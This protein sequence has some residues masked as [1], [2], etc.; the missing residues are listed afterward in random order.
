VGIIEPGHLVLILLIALI[1]FGPGRLG[2]LGGTLGRGLRDFRDATEGKEPV[3]PALSAGHCTACG[4]ALVGDAKFCAA[5]GK[6][7][8]VAA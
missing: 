4:A 2:D 1:V 5:C 6:A 8:G 7:V 3:R